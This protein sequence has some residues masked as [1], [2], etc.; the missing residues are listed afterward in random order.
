MD[1]IILNQFQRFVM[2]RF[3]REAWPALVRTANVTLGEGLLAVDAVYRDADLMALL[4]AVTRASGLPATALLQDFG[5]YLAPT[6]LRV[7]EPLVDP[8]WRTLEVIEHTESAIH[9]VVRQRNPNATPP[10]LRVRRVA[11]HEVAIDYRSER[12]L[13]SLAIGIVRGLAQ[14][15]AE[16]VVITE[17]ECMHRGDSR[18][19]IHVTCADLTT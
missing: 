9:T 8:A 10:E 15:F 11:P 19:L 18:C 4:A 14:H 16:L 2:Q 6:L 17:P 12:R 13:C 3:G 5:T 7:Y 1:G